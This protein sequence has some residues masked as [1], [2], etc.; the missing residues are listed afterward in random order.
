MWQ[1]KIVVTLKKGVLDPQGDVVRRSLETMGYQG[2]ED[3]R[4]GKFMLVKLDSAS[5]EEAWQQVD[6]ICQKLL[7]NP[8]I[9]E[10]DFELTEAG[11]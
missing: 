7:A 6:E 2:I 1:A 11:K 5:R 10:Y 4:V 9:E 8:V 3:V